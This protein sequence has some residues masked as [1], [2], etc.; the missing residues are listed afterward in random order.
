[1]D[2][3]NA[4]VFEAGEGKDDLVVEAVDVGA[5]IGP[6]DQ[7]EVP[8]PEHYR[9][10]AEA[11]ARASGEREEPRDRVEA[12][13]ASDDD[14]DD[15]KEFKNVHGYA[16]KLERDNHLLMARLDQLARLVAQSGAASEVEQG[17]EDEGEAPDPDLDPMG[18]L[19][20]EIRSIKKKLD[21]SEEEKR[22]AEASNMIR[23][24]MNRADS[25]I[26]EVEAIDPPQFNAAVTYLANIVR[27]DI[28]ERFPGTT[29]SEKLHIAG[30]MIGDLK[31][32][33][34]A[35]GKN[36]GA[37]YVKRAYRFGFKWDPRSQE[38]PGR[39]DPRDEIRRHRER[40][41][42][43]RSIA[44]VQG[45]APKSSRTG[46]DL[47][48]MSPQEFNEYVNSSIASGKMHRR[49]G[50]HSKTPSFSELLPGKGVRSRP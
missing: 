19:T 41:G 11:A 24:A 48:R 32:R 40:E 22:K 23:A 30:R 9:A 45:A 14:D 25:M 38:R 42:K 17:D 26:A 33:W 3:E 50:T 12:R 13:D 28:E 44:S 35:E 1:M 5:E 36:P 20:H 6:D 10:R 47:M 39:V 4:P 21:G 46:R 37:E 7:I 18:A 34:L 8:F 49:S 31:L 15:D 29:D 2:R 16:R 27:E 43:T